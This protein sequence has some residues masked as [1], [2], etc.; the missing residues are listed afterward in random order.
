[1]AREKLG[2]E[3]LHRGQLEAIERGE[4][5]F[6]LLAPEQPAKP[7]VLADLAAA[8]PR[9]WSR[10]GP[11]HQP[12][13]ARLPPRLPAAGRLRRAA[14]PSER[15]FPIGAAVAHK[16]WGV[17]EVQRYDRDRVVVLFESVGY[18]TLDLTVV[19]EEELLT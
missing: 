1:M 11:L 4:H 16:S 13:G 10:R 15:P 5:E 17:G 12:V 18:R 6:V 19:E 8:E 2:I 3:K 7:E 9:C 14:R